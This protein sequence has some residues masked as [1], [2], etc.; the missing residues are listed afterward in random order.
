[1]IFISRNLLSL[2]WNLALTSLNAFLVNYDVYRS[3]YIQCQLQLS[4]NIF[5][6][7]KEKHNQLLKR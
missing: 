2:S 1:M 7:K 6:L 4:F 3:K 5:N